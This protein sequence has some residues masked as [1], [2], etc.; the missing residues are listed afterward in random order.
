MM[1]NVRKIVLLT[2][3][4][5][6]NGYHIA[7]A[8][9]AFTYSNPITITNDTDGLI[10]FG[11]WYDNTAGSYVPTDNATATTLGK[12]QQGQSASIRYIKGVAK[13]LITVGVQDKNGVVQQWPWPASGALHVTTAVSI[14]NPFQVGQYYDLSKADKGVGGWASVHNNCWNQD[15]IAALKHVRYTDQKADT[16]VHA[17]ILCCLLGVING[18]LRVR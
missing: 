12:L 7:A 4:L 5:I 18:V 3:L 1:N 2:S 13:K 6:M 17:E 14:K 15:I 8:S 9:Q 16:H 10:T 11:V